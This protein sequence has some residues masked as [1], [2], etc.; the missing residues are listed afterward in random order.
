MGCVDILDLNKRLGLMK[1]DRNGGTG[2]EGVKVNNHEG[3]RP[4]KHITPIR[5]TTVINYTTNKQ[6]QKV[7][8]VSPTSVPSALALA[9]C[10]HTMTRFSCTTVTEVATTTTTKVK[11]G[12][13][14]VI[15]TFSSTSKNWELSR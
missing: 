10:L 2:R 14:A 3:K 11:M 7:T 9:V 6:R 4:E 8:R 12:M 1:E 15:T 5:T 13:V